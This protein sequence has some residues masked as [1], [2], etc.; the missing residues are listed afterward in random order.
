MQRRQPFTDT[1]L[2]AF[3]FIADLELAPDGSRVAFTR[4]SVDISGNGYRS[5][6][7]VAGVRGKRQATPLTN[8][9]HRDTRPRFSPDGA[10]LAFLSDRDE[11]LANGGDDDEP[12][13]GP[14]VFVLPLGGGEARRVTSIPGGVDDFVWCPQSR[15]LAVVARLP[16][17]G[18][19]AL[20]GTPST[21]REQGGARNSTLKRLFELHTRDVQC[22]QR[23]EQRREGSG[24]LED[25]RS[26]VVVIDVQQGL[27]AGRLPVPVEVTAGP[28]DH[29]APAWSPNG[30]LLAVS[31]AR[32][33][34]GATAGAV[35]VWLFPAEPGAQGG[36]GANRFPVRVTSGNGVF[37][38][39]SFSPDGKRIAFLGYFGPDA[40]YAD[41][42]LWIV[43]LES[44]RPGPMVCLT[45][46]HGRSV[47]DQALLDMCLGGDDC[48]PAWSADGRHVYFLAS[49]RGTTHLYGVCVTTGAVRRLTSGDVVLY[50]MALRPHV[51]T[52]AVAIATPTNPA[53]I[54]V[55]RLPGDGVDEQMSEPSLSDPVGGRGIRLYRRTECNR[56]L[57]ARR[58]VVAPE[59]FVCRAGTGPEVEGW[60][61][62]P[63]GL[64]AGEQCPVVL[65]IHGGPQAMYTGAFSFEFQLLASRG[66]GVVATNPRGSQGYGEQFC[67]ELAKGWG[68]G[69]FADIIAGI[70]AAAA[71]F[72]WIDGSRVGVAGASYGGYLAAWAIGHTDR[73]RAACVMWPV[74]NAYSFVGTSDIGQRWQKVWCGEVTPWDDPTALIRMSPIAY[75]GHVRTPTL[76]IQGEDDARC[77]AEQSEQLFAAL[78]AQGVDVEFLRYPGEGHG[79][80]LGGS[81]WHRVHRLRR[82][83]EWFASRL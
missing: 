4:T 33:T 28:Y 66:I 67:S 20:S 56:R 77:P 81:P 76:I 70:D 68:R 73:F 30:R 15:R 72:E 61:W 69:D 60:V 51:R 48:R 42:R 14:Q 18:V 53:D 59:R 80:S 50:D 44:N 71:R 49:D 75:A 39:S 6:V 16:P 13:L 24:W 31:A 8:G 55:G 17:C 78:R 11:L 43:E 22:V 26:Q 27:S 34:P 12:W 35:D 38:E 57:L 10:Y 3:Q 54:Y 74:S 63:E 7:L 2:L 1:D 36:A 29:Y 46:K 5:Q 32:L 52:L 47:G 21:A 65:H 83:L 25:G 64:A 9:P 79:F 19:E 41:T 23:L 58:V 45:A 62:K 40:V 82:T 37:G